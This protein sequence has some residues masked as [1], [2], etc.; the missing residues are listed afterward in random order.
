M[1]ED[2]I[3]CDGIVSEVLAGNNFKVTVI[4][5]DGNYGHTVLCYLGGKV[6]QNGIRIILHDKVRLA[7]SPYDATKGK[8]IFREK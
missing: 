3:E 7:I 4:N 2:L 5:A 6:R 1:K 8:I